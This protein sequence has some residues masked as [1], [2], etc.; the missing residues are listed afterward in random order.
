MVRFAKVGGDIRDVE[1]A[2]NTR[3]RAERVAAAKLRALIGE[4][5]R[6][7]W[8]ERVTFMGPL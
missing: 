5:Y 4:E 8:V 7:W 2:A 3:S 1:A 6:K